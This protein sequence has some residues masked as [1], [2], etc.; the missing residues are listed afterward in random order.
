MKTLATALALLGLGCAPSLPPRWATGGAALELP[1]ARWTRPGNDPIDLR[2]DGRVF[3]GG[4]LV[5]RIDRVGRIVDDEYEPVAL[6]LPDGRVVGTDDTLLGQVGITNAA[7]PGED[8]AWLTVAP[9]GQVIYFA[10]DG[11]RVAGGTWSGCSGPAHRTCTY[12]THL[13]TLQN[14]LRQP[15]PGVSVGVGFGVGF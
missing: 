7:P 3:E 10:Q 8:H 9:S 2:P 6:L 13:I 4:S 15:N 14:A 12:V 5:F 1:A 11:T